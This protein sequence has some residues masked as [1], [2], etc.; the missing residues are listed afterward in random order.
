MVEGIPIFNMAPLSIVIFLPMLGA[1]LLALPTFSASTPTGDH[2][3][4]LVSLWVTAVTFFLSVFVLLDFDGGSSAM[5]FTEFYPWF[6]QFGVNYVL[7]VDGISIFLVLLTTFIMPLIVL[8]SHSITTKLRGYLASM[9]LLETA[10]LGT[11]LALDSF[12]FYV[13]WELMLAP[14]YFII[15]IWGGKRRIYATLKF[16]LYTVFGSLLMLVALLYVV[17]AHY[18]QTGQLSFLLSDLLQVH[19]T[20]GEE[21]WLFAAFALAF[22]IKV[23]IFPFHTWLPD[24]HV[25]APTGGSVVLAGVLLK[26]GL[27][28]FIRFAYPLFPRGAEVFAPYIAGLAVIG[29]IYGALVAWAQTDIKKL[30][31]YS[32]VSHL[33]YCVLGVVAFNVVSTTGSIFQMLSHGV[34]TGALFL[35][36]GVLYDRR[37]TREIAE[38]GGLASKV[39]IFAFLFLVFTLG[40]IALPL[41]NGFVGEFLILIGSFQTFKLLTSLAVL[42]VIFGAVYM[43]TLYLKTMF[44]ELNEEKNGALTDV[45]VREFATFMPLLFLVFW[46]GVYPAPILS[47]MEASVENYITVVK[48]RG[49]RLAQVHRSTIDSLEEESGEATPHIETFGVRFQASVETSV[50]EEL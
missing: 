37:H 32:S 29:I 14:M 9:L 39:P 31:A 27:Y 17:W 2:K 38:Y 47:R 18:A 28:G 41:T 33:G 1:L 50:S 43:L 10:M 15:G 20:L 11:L 24:A 26:M 3:S 49:K 35:L 6:P 21:V 23:P 19:L 8:A 34:T 4:Y 5:Q 7:G 45:T 48:Q 12:L 13:F 42:G 36:V 16:V 44:G 22:G 25:E 46:M 30:V 40:S